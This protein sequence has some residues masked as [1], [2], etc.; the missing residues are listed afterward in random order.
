MLSRVQRRVSRAI[1]GACLL[2]AT[3]FAGDAHA[4]VID[5]E[6]LPVC[7]T[8][9]PS[10]CNVGLTYSEKGFTLTAIGTSQDPFLTFAPSD[11]R[12]AS[13]KTLYNANVLGITQLTRD[14]GGLFGITS[15][16]LAK[17]ARFGDAPITF[18]GTFADATTVTQSFTIRLGTLSRFVFANTFQGLTKLEWKQESP[19][20][21]FD[22]IVLTESGPVS[23]PESGPPIALVAGLWVA[24]TALARSRCA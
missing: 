21:Q 9:S 1:A 19:Y 12:Y 17:D 14:G 4:T 20:H 8:S 11:P 13:S 22:D 2:G 24:A 23:V 10:W 6:S 15:I 3:L 5:F 16:N 18:V 7:A